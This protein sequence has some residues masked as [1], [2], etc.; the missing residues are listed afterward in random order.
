MELLNNTFLKA[1][2]Y[3]G[4]LELLLRDVLIDPSTNLDDEFYKLIEVSRDIIQVIFQNLE[5]A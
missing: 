4:Y 5:L 3:L 1:I 2:A